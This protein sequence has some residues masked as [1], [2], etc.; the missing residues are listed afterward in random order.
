MRIAVSATGFLLIRGD[1]LKPGFLCHPEEGIHAGNHF[2]I[3]N[4]AG[5]YYLAVFN[6]HNDLHFFV[7]DRG[8]L[9][10]SYFLRL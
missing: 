1:H 8:G 7:R 9:V 6:R 4:F 3:A 5:I 10:I 2:V